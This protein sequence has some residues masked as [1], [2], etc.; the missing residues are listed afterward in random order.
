MYSKNTYKFITNIKVKSCF[1]SKFVK[2][3]THS[4]MAGN[5]PNV[6]MS[7]NVNNLLSN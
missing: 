5:I 1:Q 3:V 7:K 4:L 2:C 6:R